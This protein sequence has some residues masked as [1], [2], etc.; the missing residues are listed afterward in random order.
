MGKAVPILRSW[1]YYFGSAKVKLG[2]FIARSSVKL[3]IRHT[4]CNHP[5][6]VSKDYKTDIA[7]IEP[8]AAKEGQD[9]DKDAD[10]LVAA[11]GQLGV[12]RKCAMCQIP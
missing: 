7:G 5:C 3:L 10:D 9:L 4:A 1:Y 6:L 2:T 11:F 12:T 8:V